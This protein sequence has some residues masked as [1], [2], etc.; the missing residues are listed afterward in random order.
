MKTSK[1]TTTEF[2]IVKAVMAFLKLDDAGKVSKFFKGIIA[3]AEYQIEVKQ[4]LI[5][6]QQ[7]QNKTEQLKFNRQIEDAE[8]ELENAYLNVEVEKIKNNSDI[9]T[10]TSI[11][12]TGISKAEANVKLLKDAKTENNTNFKTNVEK[13]ELEIKAL[14]DRIEKVKNYKK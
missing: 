11:Y 12:L 8:M 4:Q 3:D 2:S 6:A 1:E 14:Q 13:V 10:Y 9:T 5:T 7:L